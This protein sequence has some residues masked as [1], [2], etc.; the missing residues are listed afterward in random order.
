MTA[1]QPC[2][3]LIL[4]VLFPNNRLGFEEI[5]REVDYSRGTVNNHLQNLYGEQKVKQESGRGSRKYYLSKSGRIQAGKLFFAQKAYKVAYD[6]EDAVDIKST[7]EELRSLINLA[8]EKYPRDLNAFFSC[9]A[10]LSQKPIIGIFK[11]PPK[12]E[13]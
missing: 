3:D 4:M 13:S 9:Y 8:L 6:K 5:V 2:P 12:K 1:K 7:L 10:E 11:L